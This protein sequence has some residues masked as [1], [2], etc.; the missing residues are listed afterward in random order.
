MYTNPLQKYVFTAQR[1]EVFDQH[2]KVFKPLN[3]TLK[4]A[5]NESDLNIDT[6]R[7]V[8]FAWFL[9]WKIPN[10]KL[11]QDWMRTTKSNIASEIKQVNIFG[12]ILFTQTE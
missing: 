6:I 12:M 5:I 10:I 9:S 7:K 11:Y 2:P 4:N 8:D 3:A 1:S